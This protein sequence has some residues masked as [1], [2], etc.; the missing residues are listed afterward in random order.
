MTAIEL[1]AG[2]P[3]GHQWRLIAR[4]P[5]GADTAVLWLPALG[6]PARH[7]LP[8]AETL[9]A[10]GIAVVLHE[11]RGLGS[12]SLRAGREQDWGYREVLAHDIATSAELARSRIGARHWIVGGH[13]LGGQLA[14]CHAGIS[15]HDYD[16]L[17]L[18]ASGTPYWRTFAP[19]RRYLLPA[20]YHLLPWIARGNGALPGRRLGFGGNEARS[21]IRDWAAVGRSNRYRASGLDRDLE[22]ALARGTAPVRGVLLRDDWL[23]PMPSL[24]GL[25]AKMPAARFSAATL[26]PEQLGVPAD[27]FA[28]MKQPQAVV[29]ALLAEA[30]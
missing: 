9:A 30:S 3:D 12:S 11:W 29:D 7:Y 22:Q 1:D 18:V 25:A 24:A 23:A 16:A 20:L 14:C 10:R 13:S 15:E 4:Q 28:W 17:W 27:H 8:M 26:A 6:V 21:L 5:A 2:G 19:P